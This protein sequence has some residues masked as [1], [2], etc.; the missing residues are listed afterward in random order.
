VTPGSIGTISGNRLK[1]SA[2]AADEGIFFVHATGNAGPVKVAAVQGNKPGQLVFL[3][4]ALPAGGYFVE[5]RARMTNGQELRTG[6]LDS[7]LTV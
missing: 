3:V 4:P 6:R 7:V 1:F 2:A 5:V